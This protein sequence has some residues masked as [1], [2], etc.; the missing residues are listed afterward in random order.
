MEKDYI[1]MYIRWSMD[2]LTF[3]LGSSDRG[4]NNKAVAINHN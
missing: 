1:M 2:I 4:I 3:F